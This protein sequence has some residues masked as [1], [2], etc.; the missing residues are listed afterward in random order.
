MKRILS[1][2]LCTLLVMSTCSCSGGKSVDEQFISSLEK[3][4]EA[5]WQLTDKTN[6]PTKEDWEKYVKA[7]LDEI[8]KYKDEKFEDKKI[9]KV[10]K[11]YI[12]SIEDTKKILKYVNTNQWMT[13]Y[14]MGIYMTRTKALYDINQIKTLE[15]KEEYKEDLTRLISTGEAASLAK[16]IMEDVKFKKVKG[17]YDYRTYA[18]IIENTSTIDFQSF[19]LSVALYDK[20]GIIVDTQDVYV[21]SWNA[22]E[23]AKFEFGTSK[24]F[25]KIKIKNV[26]WE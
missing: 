1:F 13:K 24:E 19:W 9:E 12:K 17:E 14:D 2:I 15:V 25:S 11:T 20:N 22:G 7:E 6:T 5:R 23:K 3:G 21:S 18:A 26:T 10:A 4:L 16:K 8:L